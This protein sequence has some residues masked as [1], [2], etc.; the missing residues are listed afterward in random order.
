[1]DKKTRIGCIIAAQDFEIQ[2]LLQ[3]LHVV[4]SQ[5]ENSQQAAA[6]L[7]DELDFRGKELLESIMLKRYGKNTKRYEEFALNILNACFSTKLWH[8]FAISPNTMY[9]EA[10]RSSSRGCVDHCNSRWVHR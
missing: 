7:R 5:V 1:M 4:N 10:D 9:A 3:Q 2:H 6:D 8:A